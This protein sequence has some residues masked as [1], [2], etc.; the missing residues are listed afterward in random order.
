[1]HFSRRETSQWRL[2]E[3]LWGEHLQRGDRSSW[4]KIKLQETLAICCPKPS[5]RVRTFCPSVLRNLSP[6]TC[7]QNINIHPSLPY[8]GHKLPK[9]I[10][11]LGSFHAKSSHEYLTLLAAASYHITRCFVSNVA[12]LVVTKPISILSFYCSLVQHNIIILLLGCHFQNFSCND[13]S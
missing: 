3:F 1:M 9:G 13:L 7:P 2:Q 5:L 12:L 11:I 8:L 4:R 6:E 10:S